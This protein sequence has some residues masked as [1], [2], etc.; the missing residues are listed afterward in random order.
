MPKRERRKNPKRLI[1]ISY[2]REDARTASR[3]YTD[4]RELG[5]E[6]WLDV[7][8]IRGGQPWERALRTAL[9]S[10][11]HVL[12]LISK[13]SVGKRGFVQREVRQALDILDEFPPER[14]FVIPVR[15]E[16]IQPQHERLATLN[17]VDLFP[18]YERGFGRLAQSLGL[19]ELKRSMLGREDVAF[20][21]HALRQCKRLKY[22]TEEIISFL[23]TEHQRHT[24]AYAHEFSAMPL[25]FRN[26]LL[27]LSWDLRTLEVEAVA[28]VAQLIPNLDGWSSLMSAYRQCMK[29]PYR[30]SFTA[31]L[32]L[33]ADADRALAFVRKTVAAAKVFFA[34]TNGLDELELDSALQDAE[35]ALLD[36]NVRLAIS[37]FEWI[38]SSVHKLLL[39]NV[40]MHGDYARPQVP[41]EFLGDAAELKILVVD[42]AA[43]VCKMVS[44]MIGAAGYSVSIAYNAAEAMKLLVNQDFLAV[45]SDVVM[46]G[47][48]G[49]TLA[50]IISQ[51]LPQTV[52][53]LMSG[54]DNPKL[55]GDLPFLQ[56]PFRPEDLIEFLN[57]NLAEQRYRG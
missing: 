52:V 33:K 25:I 55:A 41:E 1:F 6:P 31:A 4:L 18:S 11:T 37:R 57:R 53:M 50:K 51:K 39:R 42:D 54:Y 38:L 8:D 2:A 5:A 26:H 15:L 30:T 16:D 29:L 14:N 9:K 43:E 49:I 56:K 35:F 32:L 3:L 21:E 19:L 34:R 44:V 10:S 45:L 46:P 22:N 23:I 7:E 27:L 17:W 12:I 40:P 47:I 48:D 36:D 28:P 24:L 13:Y 20:R